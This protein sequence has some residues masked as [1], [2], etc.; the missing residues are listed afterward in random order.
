MKSAALP[1]RQVASLIFFVAFAL[2]MIWAM[3]TA[4]VWEDYFITYRSSK[5]L[6]TGNG[7]VF[8]VGDRLHTFT[9]PLGVLL[10]A[11]ASLLTGNRSDEWAL[12]IFRC[13]SGMAFAGS[14]V[15]LYV[16]TRQLQYRTWMTLA[17]VGFLVSDGKSLDF[18]VN[19]ME[20]GFLL[21][22]IS[23]TLWAMWVGRSRRV[24][25]LGVAWAGLMWTRPDSFLYIALLSS[26][27]LFFNDE[28]R[29]A[30]NRI[31]LVGLFIRAG[32]VCALLYLPWFLWAWSYYG[33]PIPHTITAKGGVSGTGKSVMGLLKT[34]LN[35][36]WTVW[37]KT[38]SLESTFMPSYF[39]LGGWPQ[40]IIRIAQTVSVAIAFQWVI[41]WWRSEVRVASFAFCGLHSYLS[42]FPY[43]PFPWYLPGTLLLAAIVLGGLAD[44]LIG[45]AT[46]KTDT[47]VRRWVRFATVVT[48]V[49]GLGVEC[50]TTF[51][52][53]REMKL[54]QIYSSTGVRR[55]VGEWL[56]T[57]AHKGDTVFM[58]P[59]GNIGYFSGLKTYDFPG[60][61][62]R[63][64]VEA[65]RLVGVDWAYLVEYLSPDWIVLRP[66]EREKIANSIHRIFNENN[67]YKL[68]KEFN[69]LPFVEALEV[70]G[71]KY[72][73]FDSHLLV[74]HRQ[75]PRRYKLDSAEV[76]PFEKLRLPVVYIDGQRMY[77]VHA[78]GMVSV[79][80]P[81]KARHVRISYG[82]PEPTYNGETVTDGV[83]FSATWSD[84]RSS[85]KLLARFV[86]P[87]IRKEDRG[88]QFLEVDLPFSDK[89]ASILLM[90]R[91][92]PGDVMDWSCWS[93]PEF[94]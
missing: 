94:K 38:T 52:M 4:H 46:T 67:A 53:N 10:P 92:G 6:A 73:E 89:P 45:P 86:S 29:T 31:Q 76:F 58:E 47:F 21:F 88:A 19:G 85:E 40:V 61:S 93:M 78:T 12:W 14:V 42:Y 1:N 75:V 11:A 7:L 39:Q 81:P 69:N 84:G 49:G 32:L 65:I 63:E 90:T 62:S 37:L 34:F 48:V 50:W 36:P 17:V 43:F 64:T 55:K 87:V 20:T 3:T 8:N 72:I 82:L 13:W 18:S 5:N 9:S 68:V 80:V 41:P 2:A 22:F 24:L 35:F 28:S 59:L 16:L 71:R 51:Q 60:L 66:H 27:A 79:T 54:E 91:C 44:Q 57:N 15:F 30:L 56:G 77:T 25:H 23:Y 33:T 70:Y 74:Y 83:E 26:G